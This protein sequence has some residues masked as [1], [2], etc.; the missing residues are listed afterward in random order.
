M[1]LFYLVAFGVSRAGR[2]LLLSFFFVSTSSFVLASQNIARVCGCRTSSIW[3]TVC[4]LQLQACLFSPP[5]CVSVSVPAR[6]VF[7][8]RV[9]CTC[10]IWYPNEQ[11]KSAQPKEKHDKNAAHVS[12]NE[13]MI[14]QPKQDGPTKQK[15]VQ[16]QQ[17]V[18]STNTKPTN[19]SPSSCPHLSKRGNCITPTDCQTT[20]NSSPIRLRV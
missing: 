6:V 13:A 9:H 4:L 17:K 10:P 7:A 16:Q 19:R 15:G 8:P 12:R 5:C 2:C 11:Q 18:N 14:V 1:S 20:I 3:V